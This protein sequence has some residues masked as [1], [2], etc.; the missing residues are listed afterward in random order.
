MSVDEGNQTMRARRVYYNYRQEYKSQLT[1]NIH[2]CSPELHVTQHTYINTNKLTQ[3]KKYI[4][5]YIVVMI[6]LAGDTTGELRSV[7]GVP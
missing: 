6:L 5:I 1:K 4:Y 3:K 7:G 2:T